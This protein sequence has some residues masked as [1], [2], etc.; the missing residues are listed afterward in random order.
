VWRALV[1][2]DPDQALSVNALAE[3]AG[4]SRAQVERAL[5]RFEAADLVLR[6]PLGKHAAPGWMLAGGV[7]EGVGIAHSAPDPTGYGHAAALLAND[8]GAKF[9]G[10]V[11]AVA[12]DALSVTPRTGSYAVGRVR[13]PPRLAKGELE[14]KVLAV[15]RERCPQEFGPLGLSRELGGYSSGAVSNALDRLHTKGLIQQTCPAP[16]R[17]AALP[18]DAVKGGQ[19]HVT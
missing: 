6:V 11:E 4:M 1:S 15:L 12:E 5:D 10:L 9:A 19:E 16:K 7:R 2:A 3:R 13:K 17:Y 14:A 8:S 18:T